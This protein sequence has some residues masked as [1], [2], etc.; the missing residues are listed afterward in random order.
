MLLCEPSPNTGQPTS[1]ICLKIGTPK[2]NVVL[3]AVHEKTP[4]PSKGP[5]PG[6]I[7]P[8]TPKLPTFFKNRTLLLAEL[9]PPVGSFHVLI[10]GEH[11]G[12]CREGFSHGSPQPEPPAAKKTPAAFSASCFAARTAARA[13]LRGSSRAFWR[14]RRREEGLAP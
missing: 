8:G 9:D 5:S 1:W 4:P 10:A 3:D 14:R 2:S 13:A 7:Q 6:N 12:R 11:R